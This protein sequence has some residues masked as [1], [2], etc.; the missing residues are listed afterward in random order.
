MLVKGN[1]KQNGNGQ[2]IAVWALADPINKHESNLCTSISQ[3]IINIISIIIKN[4]V[5]GAYFMCF[6]SFLKMWCS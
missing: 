4:I 2:I 6:E 5:G 1:S 3:P